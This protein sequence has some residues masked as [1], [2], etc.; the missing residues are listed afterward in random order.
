MLRFRL[1]PF[2]VHVA[3]SFLIAAAI[4]GFPFMNDLAIVALWIAV[5]FVSVLIHELGH[6]LVGKALGGRPEIQLEGFGGV[7]F[8]RLP[9]PPSATSQI[10]LSLAGP[11]AGLLP[12]AAGWAIDRFVA[13]EPGSALAIAAGLAFTTSLFWTVLNLLP[14]LPLDGGQVL[15]AALQ[16]I[17]KKPSVRAASIISACV[18]GLAAAAAYFLFRQ[19][20]VAIWLLLFAFQ[21]FSRVRAAPV[22]EQSDAPAPL[23]EAPSDERADVDRELSRARAALLARDEETA[24]AVASKLEESEGAFRQA[25]GLRIRAGVELARGDNVSAGLH[26]GRSYTLWESPDAAVVAARANLRAG[27]RE[28]ALNWLRRA[29]EAGAHPAAVREDP[30]LGPLT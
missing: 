2:P 15:L 22:A 29:V 30:E 17:R 7:T 1:G 11:L 14:V 12:G 20:F 25:A 4:L 5:V 26:A 13:P 24:L 28:R 16:G 27:E 23:R 6:A 9:A 21:N 10:G 18:A 19:V 8:P 3:P